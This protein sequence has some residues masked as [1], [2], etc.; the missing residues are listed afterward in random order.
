[1]QYIQNVTKQASQEHSE[2]GSGA[3]SNQKM[4]ATQNKKTKVPCLTLCYLSNKST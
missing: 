2:R 4:L 3:K 1:M